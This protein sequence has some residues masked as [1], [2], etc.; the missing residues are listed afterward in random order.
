MQ[1]RRFGMDQM[2]S[3]VIEDVESLLNTRCKI[4]SVPDAYKE[5]NDSLL[6]YGIKDFTSQNP[7]DLSVR[8]ELRS[9][10]EKTIKQFEPRLE[11]LS[12]ILEE[13]KQNKRNLVFRI[14][15][16]LEMGPVVEQVVFDTF[17]DVNSGKY[18]VST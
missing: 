14:S 10:I 8:Q 17:F 11:K 15:A 6:G 1:G 9:G 3:C 7:K 2:K 16:M 4:F 12:V 18:S 5:V 13:S